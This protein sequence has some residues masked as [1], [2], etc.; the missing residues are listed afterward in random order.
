MGVFLTGGVGRVLVMV[1]NGLFGMMGVLNRGYGVF[2]V[3]G[4]G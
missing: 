4:G 1:Y 3:I 2:G